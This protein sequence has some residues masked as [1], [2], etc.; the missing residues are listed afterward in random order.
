MLIV[1]IIALVLR[2]LL[3]A[4]LLLLTLRA[5]LGWVPL[6]VRGWEPRGIVRVVAEFVLTVTDPPLRF[7]QRHLPPVRV[8]G[9]RFDTAFAALYVVVLVLLGALPF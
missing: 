6:F 8:G 5:V 7:L 4:F 9:A 2:W 1:G 3:G